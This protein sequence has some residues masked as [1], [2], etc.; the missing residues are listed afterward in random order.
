MLD[1]VRLAGAAWPEKKGRILVAEDAAKVQIS[2]D[3][4]SVF[5]T[6]NEM[7]LIDII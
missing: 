2:F 3:H 6:K 5:L 7:L 1:E 4:S